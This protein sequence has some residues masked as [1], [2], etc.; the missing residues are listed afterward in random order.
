MRAE[1]GIEVQT[2]LH[3]PGRS[4]YACLPSL[5]VTYGEVDQYS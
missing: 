3:S 4:K 1:Q 2:L 5:T